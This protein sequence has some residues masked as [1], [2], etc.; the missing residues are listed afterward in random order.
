ME[1]T[2]GCSL[3]DLRTHRTYRQYACI[4]VENPLYPGYLDSNTEADLS[5]LGREVSQRIILDGPYI[6]LNPG[7][8]EPRARELALQKINQA[9]RYARRCHA[10]EIIF[11]STFL[12]WIGMSFYERGWI[13]ESIRSWRQVLAQN[14]SV[15]I[16]L[17]NTFE[18]EPSYLLEIVETIQSPQ[19]GLAFDVGHCLVWGKITPAK[20]YQRIREHCRTIYLHSNDGKADQHLSV[21]EGL[22]VEGKV[23]DELMQNFKEDSILI[24]KYFNKD[25]VEDDIQYLVSMIGS[26]LQIN[27]GNISAIEKRT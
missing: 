19:L 25:N 22:L 27:K 16:S 5:Y 4:N 24:L 17:C 1:I 8:P 23:L 3:N 26:V 10:E 15:R 9:I 18:F 2:L 14:P 6:D 12:P 20:W 7:S 11:L 21:R 13:E